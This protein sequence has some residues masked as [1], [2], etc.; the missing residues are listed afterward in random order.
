M[1]RCGV[2]NRKQDTN[3]FRLAAAWLAHDPHQTFLWV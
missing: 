3:G 2:I 1:V